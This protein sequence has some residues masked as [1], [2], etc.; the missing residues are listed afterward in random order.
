M[1]PID[2]SE[3]PRILQGYV[4]LIDKEN[5]RR[6]TDFY[7]TNYRGLYFTAAIILLVVSIYQYGCWAIGRETFLEEI[8][9]EVA[10]ERGE[11]EYDEHGNLKPK[12]NA[13]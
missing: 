3:M 9:E 2:I 7:I 5:K 12:E 11:L 6:I 13:T 10:L 8:D 1:H 4:R